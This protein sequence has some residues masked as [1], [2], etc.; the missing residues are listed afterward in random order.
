VCL[1]NADVVFFDD[2]PPAVGRAAETSRAF[3]LIGRCREVEEFE[4]ES[5]QEALRR[6]AGNAELREPGALDYFVF[7][8]EL[9]AEVPP[10][11]LGRAGFDNWLVWRARD[12]GVPIF[13]A[14]AVVAAVH[15]RH[16]YDHLL[17]GRAWAYGGDEARRNVELAGGWRHLYNVDDAT[18]L[19]TWTG[20]RTNWSGKLR[21]IVPLRR[22]WLAGRALA[23][24]IHGNPPGNLVP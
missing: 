6:Q 11:A 22:A 21:G 3:L 8:R 13:D 19:L 16:G 5:D 14:T 2:L 4:Q 10:F 7:P 17:G 12:L 9:Y 18:H 20:I 23:S 15:P 1:A 24:R